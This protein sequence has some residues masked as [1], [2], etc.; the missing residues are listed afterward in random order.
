VV[1]AS[2]GHEWG[3]EKQPG[4]DNPGARHVG[5][6]NE[7][8]VGGHDYGNLHAVRERGDAG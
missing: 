2:K 3:L 7:F 8:T 5:H 1:L 4:T 6:A